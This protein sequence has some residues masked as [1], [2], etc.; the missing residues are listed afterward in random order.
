MIKLS[1]PSKMPCYSWSLEA[2]TTCPGAKAPNGDLVPACQGC[3]ATTGN[4]RFPSVKAPRIHNQQDWERPEWVAEMVHQIHQQPHFRWFDSG[5]MYHL[6]LARKILEVMRATPNTQHW[7]P[8]RMH[9]FQK[10]RPVIRAMRKLDNVVVRVS[11]D[12]VTGQYDRRQS[13]TSTI[14]PT[15]STPTTATICRAYERDGKCGDCRACWDKS[16]KVI[17]YPAHGQKMQSVIARSN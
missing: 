13:T 11:S 7:L 2:L 3:Y 6:K 12:S 8:T 14:I 1:K 16:I 4:Y 9:K 10:F 5:D 15:A 17:A